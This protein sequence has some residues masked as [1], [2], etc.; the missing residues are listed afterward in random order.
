M[1]RCPL[2]P[3]RCGAGQKRRHYPP[4]IR[5]PSAEVQAAASEP[6]LVRGSRNGLHALLVSD[7]LRQQPFL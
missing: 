7:Q 2:A 4:V 1:V 5:S 3:L 6:A